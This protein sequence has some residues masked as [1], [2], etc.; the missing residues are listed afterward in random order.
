MDSE[1]EEAVLSVLRSRRLV[2]GEMV[3]RFE[4]AL[5]E[6]TGSR[7][8]V[9][10]NS[11]TAALHLAFLALGVTGHSVITSAFTFAAS[12]NSVLYVGAR[13]VFADISLEDYNLDPAS[14]EERLS[15]DTVAIEPVH[16]YGQPAKMDELSRIS[17]KA[18]VALVEDAAQAIGASVNGKKVGTF[19][20]MG[21]FSTYATKNL[22]TAEGGFITTNNQALAERLRRLRSHG[23]SSRYNHI[24]LG[25]NY[26][27]TELQAA[28]GLPQLGKLD[29]LN[30]KRRENAT[31]LTELLSDVEGIVTP[32]ER[33]GCV[34]VYHQYTIRVEK[35]FGSSRD[36]LAAELAK[37]G[38]ETGVHY[39]KPVYLQ[40]YYIERFGYTKGLCPNSEIAAE[41]C[42]SLP[43]HP[44]LKP[45]ELE[46]IAKGIKEVS[47]GKR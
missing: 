35:R 7:F 20:V 26:R 21:C 42:L 12:A 3:E 5:A 18:G 11:G 25:M 13:P 40:P 17:E 38:I 22:H 29:L 9:A 46:R 30:Q 23:Q 36:R 39:P 31:I 43:I 4:R 6:Y 8:A 28:I 27:M 15:E 14:V 10:V 32:V 37:M 45:E 44:S 47:E 1:I 16:L 19:G 34:H 33:K 2:S 41:S 24:E